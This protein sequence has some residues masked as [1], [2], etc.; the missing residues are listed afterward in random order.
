MTKE[1][2]TV[3]SSKQISLSVNI[4]GKQLMVSLVFQNTAKPPAG[5]P[6]LGKALAVAGVKQVLALSSV[7]SSKRFA[8]NWVSKVS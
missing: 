6:L 2:D 8:L 7:E 4:T 5:L 3:F 1:C